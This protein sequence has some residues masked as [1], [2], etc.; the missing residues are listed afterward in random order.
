DYKGQFEIIAKEPCILL[1]IDKKSVLEVLLKD[2]IIASNI[3]DIFSNE[4]INLNKKIVLFSYSLIQE[5]IAH[6]LL[7]NTEFD[8]KSTIELP[9]SKKALAERLNVPRSNLSK[10]LKKLSMQGIIEIDHKTIRILDKPQ[11]EAILSN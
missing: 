5:K 9:Y 4:I 8:N 2:S 10:E 3:L 11:L 7:N 6:F 1:L